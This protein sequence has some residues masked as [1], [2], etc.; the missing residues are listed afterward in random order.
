MAARRYELII[1]GA[2]GYTGREAVAYLAEK[3]SRLDLR[4][5]IAGRDETGP[6]IN[7]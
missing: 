2:T 7:S 5:A 6:W 3:A 4:W 1:Y